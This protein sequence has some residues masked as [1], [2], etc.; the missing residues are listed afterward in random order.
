[1][2]SHKFY[3]MSKSRMSFRDFISCFGF[4]KQLYAAFERYQNIKPPVNPSRR[5]V[6]KLV[7]RLLKE[8]TAWDARRELA[9]IGPVVVPSLLVALTDPRFHL[10]EFD[11]SSVPGPLETTLELLVSYAPDEVVRIAY[12]FAKSSSSEVRKTAALH[13]ASTGHTCTIPVL[14]ELMNDENG[15][16][17]SYVCIGIQR[18]M[19]EQRVEKEFQRQAYDLLLPQCGQN[20][21]S[22]MND[23]AD[24]IVVLDPVKAAV[25]LG[26]ERCL[27]LSNQNTHRII[28]ACSRANIVL[29]EP[30]IRRLLKEALLQAVGENVYPNQYV[31]ATALQALALQNAAN[32]RAIAESLLNHENET[33][34]EAAAAALATLAG[35]SDPT[36][37]VID[38]VSQEG[39]ESLSHA[40]RVVYCVFLFDAE[41]CNGGL[42]RFFGNSSG[43]H[44]V[45]TLAALS[46][47]GHQEGYAVLDSAMKLVGPLA[48]ESDSELRLT[49][50]EGRWDELQSAFKPLETAYYATNSQLRQ[51]WLLFAVRHA[52]HF[53][54]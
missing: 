11:S 46:E 23:V 9:M 34:K 6:D 38:R 32:T 4:R 45:D 20:W 29:P 25:D 24:T 49:A 53:R 18:A 43:S 22:A 47:L 40:Q 27:N 8:G 50:F 19:T 37:L 3:Y 16:V 28:E 2:K 13:L 41:V 52:D 44:A 7:A 42:M 17:R 10:A 33:I 30:A 21:G 35:V 48:R 5:Y 14:Q 26:D 51:A 39:Y 36:G 12:P 1:M 54:R 15:Y 31:A